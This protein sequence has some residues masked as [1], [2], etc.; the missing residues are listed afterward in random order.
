MGKSKQEAGINTI[1]RGAVWPNRRNRP[2]WL[3]WTGW[4]VVICEVTP[5][6]YLAARAST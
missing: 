4:A 1:R 2:S 3:H 6:R 5:G